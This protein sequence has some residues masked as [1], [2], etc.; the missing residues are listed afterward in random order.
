MGHVFSFHSR[1]LDCEILHNY[2][3]QISP[4][5]Q[6]VPGEKKSDSENLSLQFLALRDR[7]KLPESEP[8]KPQGHHAPIHA[9]RCGNPINRTPE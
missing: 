5:C 8:L 4:I 2:Y 3:N 6:F 7:L 9:Q 1:L